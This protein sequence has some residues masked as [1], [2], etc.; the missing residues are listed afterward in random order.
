MNFENNK[1]DNKVE[2]NKNLYHSN[3]LGI[4]PNGAHFTVSDKTLLEYLSGLFASQGI[5][6]YVGAKI[7]SRGRDN[8]VLNAILYFDISN[9][10]KGK[11]TNNGQTL[12][13][14]LSNEKIPTEI[15]NK[16]KFLLAPG[17]YESKEAKGN[18]TG[19][20][21]LLITL[22]D[23]NTILYSAFRM[24]NYFALDIMKISCDANDNIY[25]NVLKREIA[26]R[27]VNK[28]DIDFIESDIR[29]NK[30]N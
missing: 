25:I 13:F 15:F 16:I 7:V 21:Y 29:R 24:N 14:D 20:R 26:P 30:K 5:T 28:S 3:N 22:F 11:N 19:K 6:N 27:A 8:D 9:V 12:L 1:R 4:R 23:I 2:E 18:E 10:S 17:R